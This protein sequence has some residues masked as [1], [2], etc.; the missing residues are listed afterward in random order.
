MKIILL[1]DVKNIGKKDEIVNV[2]DGYARNYIIPNKLGVIAS[3]TSRDVLVDQKEARA[4]DHKQKIE[5]AKVVAEKLS[6]IELKFGVKV[7]KSGLV[8][9][10]ISTKQIEETLK[11]QHGIVVDKRKFKPSGSISALG[12]NTVTAVIFDTVTATFKVTLFEA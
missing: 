12:T 10:A 8:N 5:D 4:Q 9:G 1:K 6:K 11:K 7:G 2:A 3:G